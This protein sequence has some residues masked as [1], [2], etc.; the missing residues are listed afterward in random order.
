MWNTV[1]VELAKQLYIKGQEPFDLT[2]S[3]NFRDLSEDEEGEDQKAALKQCLNHVDP[4]VYLG[5]I[6]EFIETYIK[7]APYQEY[8]QP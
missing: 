5:I 4:D 8:D 1:A 6:Y 2:N 3:E 7:Q